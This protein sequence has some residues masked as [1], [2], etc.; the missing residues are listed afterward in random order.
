MAANLHDLKSAG[1]EELNN[2]PQAEIQDLINRIPRR[3]LEV[4]WARGGD[5]E[6]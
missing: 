2:I 3:L 6:C 1:V 5:S 4:I